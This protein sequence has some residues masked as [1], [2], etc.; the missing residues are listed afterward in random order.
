M[1]RFSQWISSHHDYG[2]RKRGKRAAA[3]RPMRT[4]VLVSRSS[5][6]V[7]DLFFHPPTASRHAIYLP[8]ACRHFAGA[9]FLSSYDG[10]STGASGSH[11]DSEGARA[12]AGVRA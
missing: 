4:P 9:G 11:S 7:G 3:G 8:S 1:R 10:S 2:A 5:G 12:D 6:P